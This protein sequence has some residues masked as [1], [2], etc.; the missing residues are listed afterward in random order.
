MGCLGWSDIKRDL[1]EALLVPGHQ[2]SQYGHLM[3][4][5]KGERREVIG[6]VLG[7]GD[8]QDVLLWVKE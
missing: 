1:G 4:Q 3:D 6:A 7:C 5:P 2:V 8:N